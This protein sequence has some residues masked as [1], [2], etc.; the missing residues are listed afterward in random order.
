MPLQTQKNEA[1]LL[2]ESLKLGIKISGICYN[3]GKYY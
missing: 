1:K 2:Y 3:T